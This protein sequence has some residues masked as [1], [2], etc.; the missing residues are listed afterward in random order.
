MNSIVGKPVE[1]KEFEPEVVAAV[2]K[3][4]LRDLPEN[5]LTANLL[6][7]FNELLGKSLIFISASLNP[8]SIPPS[9]NFPYFIPSIQPSLLYPHIHPFISQCIYLVNIVCESMFFRLFAHLLIHLFIQSFLPSFIPSFLPSFIQSFLS[10]FIPSFLPS[11]LLPFALY[12]I[13]ILLL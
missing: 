10:L 6:P 2:I 12:L 4:Y 9:L 5:V 1:L 8:F 7:K 3:S 11:S 13:Y